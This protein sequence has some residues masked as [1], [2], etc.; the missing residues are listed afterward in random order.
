MIGGPKPTGGRY[1]RPKAK[2][3][4]PEVKKTNTTTPS[5]NMGGLIDALDFAQ[6]KPRISQ[7]KSKLSQKASTKYKFENYVDDED[8]TSSDSDGQDYLSKRLPQI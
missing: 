5:V 3:D 7:R 6:S 1:G 8:D 2:L 4:V